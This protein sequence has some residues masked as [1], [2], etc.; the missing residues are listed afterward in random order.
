MKLSPVV[1]T[2]EPPADHPRLCEGLAP[3]MLA[4]DHQGPP[5]V[6]LTRVPPR[7][8]GTQHRGRD[9]VTTVQLE[10][11]YQRLYLRLVS[12]HSMNQINK[13]VKT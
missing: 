11:G 9:Q 1:S 8:P 3:I 6:P 2:A 12:D 13:W 7:G 10:L 4:T 5:T